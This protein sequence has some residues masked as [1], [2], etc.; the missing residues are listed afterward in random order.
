MQ[1]DVIRILSGSVCVIALLQAEAALG[2]LQLV[3]LCGDKILNQHGVVIVAL[4]GMLA[5]HEVLHTTLSG[6]HGG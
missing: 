5:W 4:P 1:H 2:P 6:S 3:V